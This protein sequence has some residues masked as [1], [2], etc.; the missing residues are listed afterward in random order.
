MSYGYEI[1]SCAA[2]RKANENGGCSVCGD[3]TWTPTRSVVFI[4]EGEDVDEYL[5]ALTNR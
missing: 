5:T 3:C 1:K 4:P 2:C